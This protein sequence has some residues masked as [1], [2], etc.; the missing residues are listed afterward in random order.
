M[1]LISFHSVL[2]DTYK[3]MTGNEEALI[4]RIVGVAGD[5]IEVKNNKYVI[6]S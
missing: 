3:A 1:A 4:K 6:P 5:T 2:L